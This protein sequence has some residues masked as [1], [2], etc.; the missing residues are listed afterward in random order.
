MRNFYRRHKWKISQ[1]ELPTVSATKISKSETWLKSCSKRC[2]KE[3][4][5]K[6]SETSLKTSNQPSVR[7]LTPFMT[8]TTARDK[9]YRPL[10]AHKATSPKPAVQQK[11]SNQTQ[12][13]EGTH[14]WL[15]QQKRGVFPKIRRVLYNYKL[16][17]QITILTTDHESWWQSKRHPS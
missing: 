3:Q 17:S 2:T 9:P 10:K 11:T 5:S 6:H 8:S 12:W 13:K 7:I 16:A 4:V 15:T 1:K 14:L